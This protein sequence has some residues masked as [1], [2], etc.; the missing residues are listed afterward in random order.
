FHMSIKLALFVFVIAGLLACGSSSELAPIPIIHTVV[1]TA[2]PKPT[3]VQTAAQ[4]PTPIIHTV[5]VTATPVP[6]APTTPTPTPPPAQV[7]TPT[8]T[9]APTPTPLPTPTPTPEPTSTPIPD[10]HG[11]DR[12]T[13][14]SAGLTLDNSPLFIRGNFEK[15]GDTDTFSFQALNGETF[16][17][18]ANFLLR[19]AIVTAVGHPKLILYSA[20]PSSPFATDDGAGNILYVTGGGT[21]YLDVSSYNAKYTG[22]YQIVVDRI[23]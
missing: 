19:G 7:P 9:M 18:S 10:D 16:V 11:D 22:D 21:M 17:F 6:T 8:A 5:V 1:V 12:T 20:S 4:A 3:V 2:T 14:T 15:P 13:S 23:K